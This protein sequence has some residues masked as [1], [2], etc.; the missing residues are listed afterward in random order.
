MTPVSKERVDPV[1]EN[2]LLALAG[3]DQCS[4]SAPD[5]VK[6]RFSVN[7]D[8]AERAYADAVA[9][10]LLDVATETERD[11]RALVEANARSRLRLHG[12]GTAITDLLGDLEHGTDQANRLVRAALLGREKRR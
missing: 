3:L 9:D 2:Y 4:A 7:L 6:N 8:R 12:T 1:L 5:D 10:G 11:F